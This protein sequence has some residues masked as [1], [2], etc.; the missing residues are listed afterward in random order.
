MLFYNHVGLTNYE[1]QEKL[2]LSE[3]S[4]Y[5]T[6]KQLNGILKEFNL[7]IHSQWQYSR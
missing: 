3:A 1:L 5:R 6:I 2:N 7:T 4:L